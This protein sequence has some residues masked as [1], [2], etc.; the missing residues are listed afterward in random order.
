MFSISEAAFCT[1]RSNMICIDSDFGSIMHV[2]T[3]GTPD[4]IQQAFDHH[5]KLYGHCLIVPILCI[6]N[7]SCAY[8]V[9][10]S[11]KHGFCT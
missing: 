9:Q 5:T 3:C 10:I 7:I 8:V 1:M 2:H 11:T 6:K 4:P